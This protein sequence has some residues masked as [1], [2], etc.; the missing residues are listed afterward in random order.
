ME[1]HSEIA[2]GLC[3]C[4]R[5]RSYRGRRALQR[6][7]S[8]AGDHFAYAQRICLAAGI[9]L[10]KPLIVMNVAIQNYVGVPLIEQAPPGA[11][12]AVITGYAC[13]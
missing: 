1:N 11:D 4:V 5:L 13:P 3:A 6:L 2:E 10:R 7:A 9:Q 12:A 8:R